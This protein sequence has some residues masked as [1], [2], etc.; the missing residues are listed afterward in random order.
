MPPIIAPQRFVGSRGAG[1]LVGR[2]QEVVAPTK[3]LE[4]HSNV[5][6]LRPVLVVG[7]E[8][9]EVVTGIEG[10]SNSFGYDRAT[11]PA[12]PVGLE[13]EDRLDLSRCSIRVE[14]RAA[15]RLAVDHRSE[16]SGSAGSSEEGV[17]VDHLPDR[18]GVLCRRAN[19]IGTSPHVA[20]LVGGELAYV[21]SGFGKLAVTSVGHDEQGRDL[22]PASSERRRERGSE[23]SVL[24][25]DVSVRVPR[26]VVQSIRL[27]NQLV[28]GQIGGR[29]LDSHEVQHEDFGELA[30]EERYAPAPRNHSFGARVLEPGQEVQRAPKIIHS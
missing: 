24:D 9:N 26:P 22:P 1:E 28:E 11:Q 6:L 2:L 3:W 19:G 13:R 20:K 12:F 14:V 4:P 15:H 30:V 8:E 27:G 29:P 10:R 17:F 23:A 18:L 5:E 7:Q 21:S 25:D 16:E